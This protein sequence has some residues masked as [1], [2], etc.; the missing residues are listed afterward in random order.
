ME[1]RNLDRKFKFK[2]ALYKFNL[3]LSRSITPHQIDLLYSVYLLSQ[4]KGFATSTQVFNHLSKMRME[5]AYN[6]VL[7]QL[8]YLASLDYLSLKRAGQNQYRLSLSGFA[9]LQQLE[10]ALRI[11]RWDR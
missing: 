2:K 3:E 7:T 6:L 8:N 4:S 9:L 10:K 11:E 1:F 5:R